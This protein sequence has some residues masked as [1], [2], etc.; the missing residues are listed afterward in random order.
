MKSH[1]DIQKIDDDADGDVGFYQSVMIHLIL[2]FKIVMLGETYLS[3]AAVLS[4]KREVDTIALR[5][6]QLH[7]DLFAGSRHLTR[8]LQTRMWKPT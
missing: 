6:L 8:A 7:S 5:I 1:I 4:M 2:G 3:A